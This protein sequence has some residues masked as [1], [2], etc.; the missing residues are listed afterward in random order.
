MTAILGSVSLFELSLL[1]SVSFLVM[2]LIPLSPTILPPFLA[3]D[4][5]CSTQCLA[6]GLCICFCQLL[7]EACLVII[8]V[9][10]DL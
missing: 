6:V 8:W 5:L 1:E 3:Q 7:D 9:G 4:V 2:F 10:I